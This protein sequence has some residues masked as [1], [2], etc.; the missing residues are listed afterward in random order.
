MIGL[1]ISDTNY[2]QSCASISFRQFGN[3]FTCRLLRCGSL[4]VLRLDR[5]I[6]GCVHGGWAEGFI[7]QGNNELGQLYLMERNIRSVCFISFN[8]LAVCPQYIWCWV[9]ILCELVGHAVGMC[10]QVHSSNPQFL[11]K[12]CL[13]S[14]TLQD[15]SCIPIVGGME[16]SKD[17][18]PSVVKAKGTAAV[19][20]MNH[21][22]YCS[23]GWS[24]GS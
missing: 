14:A 24:R 20:S 1:T 5:R 12:Q 13:A 23:L 10:L 6:A 16:G 4:S 3:L 22:Y 8:S 7:M 17:M 11:L 19:M 9:L 21:H 15:T 2:H 18:F